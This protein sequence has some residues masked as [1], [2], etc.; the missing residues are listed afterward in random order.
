M[1][2]NCKSSNPS[3][4]R[5]AVATTMETLASAC[6]TAKHL[7]ESISKFAA[8]RKETIRMLREIKC[9]LKQKIAVPALVGTTSKCG[10]FVGCIGETC[11]IGGV[12]VGGAIVGGVVG[13]PGGSVVGT[14]CLVVET[15]VKTPLLIPGTLMMI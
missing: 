2:L 4:A 7:V 1:Y 13:G 15:M 5:V 14:A 6:M 3:I 12:I 10:A 8:A 11:A 9:A